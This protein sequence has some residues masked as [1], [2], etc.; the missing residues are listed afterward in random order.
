[1]PAA[2]PYFFMSRWSVV[3]SIGRL[4]LRQEDRAR[5]G[6]AHLQPGAEC[7]GFVAYQVVLGRV[8]AF[9]PVDK[10]PV[11]LGIVVRSEETSLQSRAQQVLYCQSLPVAL[12]VGLAS[13]LP[14]ACC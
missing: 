11:G 4:L 6:S 1:M 2:A 13:G 8:R 9:Q 3:R 5:V 10:D 12:R 14:V 7:P